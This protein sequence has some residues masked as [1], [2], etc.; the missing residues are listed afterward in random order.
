MRSK[1]G[2][3][4]SKMGTIESKVGRKFEQKRKAEWAKKNYVQYTAGDILL[5]VSSVM[6]M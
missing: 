4:K 1:M 5:L 6:L 3:I 2:V